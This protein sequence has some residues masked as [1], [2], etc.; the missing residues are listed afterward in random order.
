MINLEAIL[1]QAETEVMSNNTTSLT[2]DEFSKRVK[3]AY[4]KL[5]YYQKD[6]SDIINKENT[7][8]VVKIMS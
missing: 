6:V 7:A 8:Y 2:R 3:E 1:E 5:Y 4:G